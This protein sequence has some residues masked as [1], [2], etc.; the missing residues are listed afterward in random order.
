ML[1]KLYVCNFSVSSRCCVVHCA[2]ACDVTLCCCVRACRVMRRRCYLLWSNIDVIP[3]PRYHAHTRWTRSLHAA[4]RATRQ[5]HHNHYNPWPWP[6][7]WPMSRWSELWL[8]PIH[9]EQMKVKAGQSVQ[10]SDRRTD[11]RTDATDRKTLA[12]SERRGV[13]TWWW[14]WVVVMTSVDDDERRRI[15]VEQLT[16]RRTTGHVIEADTL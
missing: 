2:A 3:R 1:F 15:I 12:A 7:H 6:W 11:G 14:R 16:W 10:S 5:H 4:D 9:T 8:L 13:I